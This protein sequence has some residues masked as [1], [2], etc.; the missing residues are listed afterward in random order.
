M[1]FLDE[2]ILKLWKA[3]HTNDVKYIM[4]GGFATNLNGFSRITNDIDIWL[5]D[6]LENR[7]KFRL[8]LKEIEVGDFENIETVEFI[9]GWSSIY[10]NSGFE[11]DVMSY[12]KG[13]EKEDFDTCYLIA[14]TAI[15]QDIPVKFLHINNLIE[16]KT[17]TARL[18][19]LIDVEELKKIQSGLTDKND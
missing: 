14:P 13:F 19:D 17:Q 5:K 7:K 15:I 3:L 16:S 12:I 11:L 1:D 9:P 10:L 6:T 2:E 18:K 4:V 8:A